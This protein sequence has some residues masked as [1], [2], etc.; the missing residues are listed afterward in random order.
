[1]SVVGSGS[2]RQWIFDAAAL[3]VLFQKI[4][5]ASTASAFSVVSCSVAVVWTRLCVP[6]LVRRA[7]LS[8]RCDR[9]LTRERRISLRLG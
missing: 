7:A 4:T 5:N 1:M 9:R 3:A 8:Y 6:K 2:I